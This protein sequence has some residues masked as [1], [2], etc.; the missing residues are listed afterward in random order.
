MNVKV[1]LGDL[2]VTLT[3]DE[4]EKLPKRFQTS[5]LKEAIDRARKQRAEFNGLGWVKP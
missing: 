4:A 5:E 1:T 3:P 2:V